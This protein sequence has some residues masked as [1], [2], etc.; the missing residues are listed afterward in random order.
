MAYKDFKNSMDL[1][2]SNEDL[3]KYIK[4]YSLLL[5]QKIDL[6]VVNSTKIQTI[7]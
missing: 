6:Y 4:I 5:N 2:F 1:S 3:L 7:I